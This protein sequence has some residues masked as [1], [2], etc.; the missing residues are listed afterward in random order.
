M[1]VLQSKKEKEK[2]RLENEKFLREVLRYVLKQDE[3]RAQAK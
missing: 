1:K 3:K 2:E